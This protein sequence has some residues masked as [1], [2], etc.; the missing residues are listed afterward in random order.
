MNKLRYG[1]GI[2]LICAIDLDWTRCCAASL[3][4][5]IKMYGNCIQG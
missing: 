2:F 3:F 4:I 5:L 1:I